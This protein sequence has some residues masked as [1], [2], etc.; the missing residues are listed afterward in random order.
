MV[1]VT[2]LLFRSTIEPFFRMT[3]QND[4]QSRPKKQVPTYIYRLQKP[5]LGQIIFKKVKK[6]AFFLKTTMKQPDYPAFA[7]VFLP[8]WTK[9][10]EPYPRRIFC[11]SGMKKKKNHRIHVCHAVYLHL[12]PVNRFSGCHRRCYK[13]VLTPGNYFTISSMV[14][15]SFIR[16]SVCRSITLII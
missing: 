4:S 16:R 9:R 13:K 3:V 15:Q 10:S 7:I 12:M 14:V 1:R 5:V 8:R 2:V 6:V 11:S